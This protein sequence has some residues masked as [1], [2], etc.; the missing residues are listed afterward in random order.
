VTVG[1]DGAIF[2]AD[3]GNH[4]IRKIALGQVSTVAGTGAVGIAD[5][6]ALTATFAYPADVA[7]AAGAVFIADAG[8]HLI[9]KLEGGEVT[10]VAGGR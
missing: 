7:W 10:L 1:A 5:G 9:R 6:P 2:V 8:N 4:R 3:T